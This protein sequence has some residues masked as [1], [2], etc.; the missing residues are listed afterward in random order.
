MLYSHCLPLSV[1]IMF[2]SR[3]Y[4]YKID[5]IL[6]LFVTHLYTDKLSCCFNEAKN[7]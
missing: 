6:W 7:G 1:S 5:M 3:S 2:K 4:P